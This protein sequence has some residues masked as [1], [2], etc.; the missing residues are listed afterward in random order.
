MA[1]IGLL[2]KQ[3]VRIGPNAS[4]ELLPV[5]AIQLDASLQEGHTAENE[6]TAFPV[7][8]GIDTTDHVRRMPDSL[9]IRGLVTDHPIT[10]GGGGT[11]KR[12]IEAYQEVKRML[13]DAKLV[14]VVTTL[15]QY[16]NMVVRSMNVPR[17]SGRGNAV[18]L[19]LSLR[20]LKT[21]EVQV[22]EGTIDKGT[23]VGVPA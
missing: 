1:Q 8:K 19:N 3:L 13:N 10:F 4:A 23:Q 6:I 5:G 22:A 15:E 7:E 11:Q 17:N 16:E 14:T 21:V 9:T 12:S 18:E 20:Q 2:F